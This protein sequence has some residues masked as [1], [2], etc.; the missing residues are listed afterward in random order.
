MCGLLSIRA[1]LQHWTAFNRTKLLLLLILA[2]AVFWHANR[3]LPVR[4][5]F[6]PDSAS[7]IGFSA[8]RPHGYS[9]FLAAYGLFSEE[10]VYLPTIQLA[11]HIA[12]IFALCTAVGM[13]LNNFLLSGGLFIIASLH[14]DKAE[15]SEV[16]SDWLY[17]SAITAACAMLI[18][19][20]RR[21]S[22]SLLIGTS[23]FIGL[24]I[25]FRTIGYVLVPAFLLPITFHARA[26]RRRLV[27]LLGYAIF[28]IAVLYCL[29][30]MSNFVRHGKFAIGSWGGMSLLGKGLVLA[31]LL[32]NSAPLAEIN[33]LAE[34]AEPVRAAVDR[35]GNPVLRALVGRQYY[36]YLRWW[37][38][39]PEFEKTWPAWRIASEAERGQ[40]AGQLALAYVVS[41]P[42]GYL[43]LVA[44]DYMSL[45]LV[46]RL[47]TPDEVSRLKS[48]LQGIGEL[49]FLS[50]FAETKEGQ[51]EYYQIVPPPTDAF[52]VY[53][54]RLTVLAFWGLSL[55]SLALL[56]LR[57]YRGAV[58]RGVPD[59]LFIMLAVHGTYLVTASVEAGIERYIMPTWSMML[60]GTIMCYALL[61]NL[62][63]TSPTAQCPFCLK[64]WS[65]TPGQLVDLA[66]RRRGSAPVNDIQRARWKAVMAAAMCSPLVGGASSPSALHG[67]RASKMTRG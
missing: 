66:K 54:K 4:P 18:L 63:S 6:S 20:A 46:P 51:Y 24:A 5:F 64:P 34:R 39:W 28:P 2:V 14:L 45:W 35:I 33:W 55:A 57:R 58:V 62:P 1:Y 9:L 50:K 32:P 44:L 11:F 42:R 65:W 22:L 16:M 26:W 19:Y 67:S 21:P 23:L 36:A 53:G 48:Q 49:P 31:K 15:V 52:T 12:S 27:T 47:F 3:D 40:L 61:G 8:L 25:T 10:L 43:G 13:R 38:A 17:A 30:S 56:L 29:A 59:L 37:L 7:Y 41:E 60:A